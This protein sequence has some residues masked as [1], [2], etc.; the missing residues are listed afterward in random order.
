MMLLHRDHV[1]KGDRISRNWVQ[2]GAGGGGSGMLPNVCVSGPW[3]KFVF[4][5]F[6]NSEV[7]FLAKRVDS[8]TCFPV[9]QESLT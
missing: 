7:T 5:L 2:G 3:G 4:N 6:P 9:T 8:A 1:A